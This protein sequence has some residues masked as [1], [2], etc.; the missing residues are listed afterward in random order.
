MKEQLSNS[1]LTVKHKVSGSE[2]ETPT[3]ISFTPTPA[4]CMRRNGTSRETSNQK[5]TAEQPKVRLFS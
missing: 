4:A 2:R 5:T 1:P 3:F